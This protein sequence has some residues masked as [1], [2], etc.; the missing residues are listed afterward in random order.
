MSKF[1]AREYLRNKRKDEEE[2]DKKAQ[3]NVKSDTFN[4]RDYLNKKNTASK[5][6]FDTF[7][8]DLNA[9]NEKLNSIV[10]GGQDTNTMAS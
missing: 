1:D 6:G 10:G 5:I 9:T 8:D 4:A 3:Q 2:E 7:S